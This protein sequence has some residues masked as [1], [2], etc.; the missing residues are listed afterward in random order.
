MA[1]S[2][3]GV[4]TYVQSCLECQRVAKQ[5]AKVPLVKMP[6][7]GQPF[8]HIAMDVVGPLAK[9]SHGYQYILVISDYATR[10]PEAYPLRR[11]TAVSVAEK[12]IDFF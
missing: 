4:K 9:T 3:K 2:G 6:I 8:A 10:Y 11:F 12:L 1:Q 5:P 7:I